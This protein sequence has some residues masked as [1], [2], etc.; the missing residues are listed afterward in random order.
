MR[1]LSEYYVCD[2]SMN[3]AKENEPELYNG[4]N[5]ENGEPV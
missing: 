3:V 4:K 5:K 1:L 2:F